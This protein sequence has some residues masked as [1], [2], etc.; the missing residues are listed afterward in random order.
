MPS[1]FKL[2]YIVVHPF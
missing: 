1:D 2:D